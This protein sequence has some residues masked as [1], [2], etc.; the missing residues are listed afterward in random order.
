MRLERPVSEEFFLLEDATGKVFPIHLR[1]ITSWEAFEYIIVDRFKG[2]KGAHR[3]QR[4]RYSLQ[5]RATRR[6]VDRSVDWDSAF[7]PY[8]KVDMSL[9]CREAQRATPT[10]SSPTCPRCFTESPGETGVEVQCQNCRMFF[11]RVVEVDEEVLPDAPTPPL[12]LARE[13]RFGQ[14]AFNVTASARTKRTREEAESEN[15]QECTCERPKRRKEQESKKRKATCD[16]P[17]SD[18]DDEDVQGFVR[19]TVISKRKRIHGPGLPFSANQ[20]ESF[21]SMAQ[22]LLG[23]KSVLSDATSRLDA[24]FSS[25]V[26]QTTKSSFGSVS[27]HPKIQLSGASFQTSRD[28]AQNED[29]DEEPWIDSSDEPSELAKPFSD[30][31]AESKSERTEPNVADN[32]SGG[33]HGNDA[34]KSSSSLANT[35]TAISPKKTIFY[36]KTFE[37][38]DSAGEDE[39][40]EVDGRTYVLPRARRTP[41]DHRNYKPQQDT[42]Y[43][44]YYPKA[45]AAMDKSSRRLASPRYTSDG[46]YATS[47]SSFTYIQSDAVA[48]EPSPRRPPRPAVGTSAAWATRHGPT[49]ASSASA[50]T[51]RTPPTVR[52]AN[53]SDAKKHRIP[54]GYSL[55]HWDPT[56]EPM[57][58]LGSVF[59]CNSLGKWIYDWTVCHHGPATPGSDLAGEFWFLL[60]S[61]ASRTRRVEFSV[62]LVT[63]AEEREVLEDHLESGERLMDKLQKLLKTCEASLIKASKK[64]EPLGKSAGVEFVTTLF[65]RDCELDKTERLMQGCR[66]FVLRF[67]ANCEYILQKLVREKDGA[68]GVQR[69][70]L[71]LL[72]REWC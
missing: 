9:M 49:A 64:G 45:D 50:Q 60:N 48:Y 63:D 65:G 57:L 56:K 27:V 70:A 34:T 36:V 42:D 46:Y 11:T 10:K 25:S 43:Y 62:D 30:E 20:T 59:D 35:T 24:S 17:E 40:I 2:R 47:K 31:A 67:D 38:E 71:R 7:L 1:T 55:K 51:K 6:A 61:I 18:S 13:A 8:Q 12:R 15:E 37:P 68:T 66:L 72:Q 16:K 28:N 32:D 29:E 53:E 41:Y 14:S 5:E 21:D 69:A 23:G 54:P 22:K 52:V 26:S 44:Y 39:Y 58:L 33:L 19:I 3:I 4:K